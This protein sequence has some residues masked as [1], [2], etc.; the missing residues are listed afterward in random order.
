M[1]FLYVVHIVRLFF[2]KNT[3]YKVKDSEA[4]NLTTAQNAYKTNC[5]H[6]NKKIKPLLIFC[7][8]LN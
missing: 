1:F 5:S 3:I 6:S 8:E 7:L 2:F 4:Q